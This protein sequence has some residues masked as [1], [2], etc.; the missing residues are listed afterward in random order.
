[1][2]RYAFAE[3]RIVVLKNLGKA[4]VQAIGEELDAIRR[5]HGGH[6]KPEDA[7]KQ[8][9]DRSSAMHRHIEWD[10][11][12]AAHSHRLEQMRVLIRSIVR[13]EGEEQVREIPAF[14]SI[15]AEDNG[16]SYLGTQEVLGSAQLRAALLKQAEKDLLAFQER[17]R[18]F[19]QLAIAVEGP[20]KLTRDLIRRE[21]GSE[22]H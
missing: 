15:R 4:N 7:L 9:K 8:A 22:E 21:T 19:E 18:R 2:T 1:M 16:R 12:T 5:E 17:Y 6:L 20:L 11:A 10:D 3:G 14:V 13:L